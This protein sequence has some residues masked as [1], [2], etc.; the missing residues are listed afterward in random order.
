M[1]TQELFSG[2]IDIWGVQG[3]VKSYLVKNN[4]IE[5]TFRRGFKEEEY[6]L[7]SSNANY[8]AMA[9]TVML[10]YSMGRALSM[11][12]YKAQVR[13]V[14]IGAITVGKRAK[15]TR[16]AHLPAGPLPG[17]GNGWRSCAAAPCRD[18]P[19]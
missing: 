9:S 1:P 2:D 18:R 16:K 4:G 14:G 19:S 12:V 7:A 6:F 8:N 5:I 13:S 11:E 10:A 3:E 17:P 15:V